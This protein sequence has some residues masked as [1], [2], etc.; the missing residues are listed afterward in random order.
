MSNRGAYSSRPEGHAE[1]DKLLVET[2]IELLKNIKQANAVGAVKF[3]E[4]Y[5][6]ISGLSVVRQEQK[7]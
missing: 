5:A 1:H 7:E 2:Q 3:A 4:A 6:L